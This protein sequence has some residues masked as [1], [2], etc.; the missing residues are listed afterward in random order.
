MKRT[1]ARAAA[2][3]A[4]ALV[5]QKWDPVCP[6]CRAQWAGLERL[7]AG[8]NR[9]RAA[10]RAVVVHWDGY[11]EPDSE[12]SEADQTGTRILREARAALAQADGDTP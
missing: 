2:P 3:P 7:V 4:A 12:W 10:L 6:T 8:R 9:L 5:L 1:C 11:G